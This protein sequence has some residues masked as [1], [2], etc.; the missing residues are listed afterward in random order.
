MENF[1]FID[2]HRTRDF[3]RKL[4]ATFEFVKQNF[5]SLGK[6][7][8]FIAGP[9]V[10]VASLIIGSFMSEFMNFSVMGNP[11]EELQAYAT[12]VTF[13]LQLALMAVFL[14]ISGVM[15]IATV[16]NYLLL[17]EKKQ[18]NKIEVSEVWEE[19]RK[20]F[21]MYFTTVFLFMILFVAA[22][23]VMLI[24][25]GLLG[26]IS[27]VLS[28]F[29]FLI[30]YCGLIYF[31]FGAAFV[32]IIRT[33]EKKGFFE[34]VFR[35]F[36]LVKDKWWSTFGLVVILY[37]IMGISSYIFLIPYYIIAGVSALHTTTAGTFQEPSLTMQVMTI[38]FFT[39][40]YLAQMV[41]TALPNVGTAFQY[42]NLVELKE[43]KGL[44]AQIET[45]GQAHP[46][47]PSAEEHF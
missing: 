12:S 15:N 44:M 11:G 21:W 31:F 24:P 10:L 9:P 39:L 1:N 32:F 4:N 23:I 13:W 30:F 47:A 8:L 20:T 18:T 36:K 26:A 19:V 7:I 46:P 29:G 14:T 5:K 45:L 16:N 34:S 3:S 33:Y 22:I 17:Y 6:S 25:M 43:A 28:V 35:S 37:M 2:F 41:L 38:V 27:P 40:Y 42:F